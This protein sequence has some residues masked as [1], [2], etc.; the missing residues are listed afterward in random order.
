ML[1]AG[2]RWGKTYLAL[3]SLLTNALAFPDSLLWYVSPT[4][5]QS[6]MIAWRLF[7][8]LIPEGIPYNPN[9][10]ELS[11]YFPHKNSIIA[12]KGAD[13]ENS[14]RGKGLGSQFNLG[15][16][17][18][19]IDEFASIFNKWEVW[20]SVLRPMLTDTN[21]GC[22]FISTPKGKDAFW[23]LYMKGQKNEDDFKSWQFKTENNP[24]LD[25]NEIERA[26]QE[27]PP[28][29]FRQEYEASFE[30]YTGLVWPEFSK[31]H[32]VKPHFIDK[33]FP[34]I[35]AIDPAISGTTGVLKAYIDEDGILTF[36]EEYYEAN[37]R[38]SEICPD[39]TED[40]DWLIDPDA[41]A[42]KIQKEGQ[43]YSLYDEYTDNGI[44]SRI[45]EKDVD[46]G[47]NRVAEHFKNNKIRIFDT[48][49]NLIWE[50][51][52]YHWTGEKE[53][54]SG[55]MKPKPYKA[56]DHLCDCL[57]YIIMERVR[58]AYI[59]RTVKPEKGSVAW[60]MEKAEREARDWKRK[61]A[62]RIPMPKM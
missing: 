21:S 48:C 33:A 62:S 9:E 52:R 41:M 26:R 18:L 45:A 32:L 25:P 1:V 10:S 24:Y 49:K 22:L 4:Y 14:L 3:I 38:I 35:G 43:L 54:S 42:K 15:G 34:R 5:R 47:I 29:Y 60:E 50:L 12:L 44:I 16:L 39:I 55:M 31:S 2:R 37:K 46:A 11:I 27:L 56:N 59:D 23:E 61:Y 6:K 30:D 19:V 8:S 51:Q 58:K 7:K 13:N 20:N 40:I 28:R 17:A 36:Y 57:R 53:T